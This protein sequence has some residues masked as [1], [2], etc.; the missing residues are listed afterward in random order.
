MPAQAPSA[1]ERRGQPSVPSSAQ[2]TAQGPGP[3]PRTGPGTASA[4]VRYVRPCVTELRLSAFE[5]HRRA[6]FALGAVTLFVGASGSGKTSALRA[7][8]A[9]ARLGGGAPLGEVFADPL[10]C[11]PQGARPDAQRRRGFRIGCT[12][13]GPG[14]PV[15][16]DVAVQAEPELR[17]VGERLSAAGV[18]LLETA[19]RDPGRRTVQAAWHTGGS[20][21][22]TRAPL[23]DDRLGT[24]LLPLR[25][26]GKTD[27]QRQVLAAAEQMVVALRSVFACDP[28]P[29][30]MGV[31]VPTGSGRLLTGCDNLA[32]VLWRTRE[33]CA[34]RHAQLVAALSAGSGAPVVDLRAEPLADGTVRALL[35]RADGSRTELARLGYG[36]LRYVALALVLLTGPGV[37]DVDPAGEV[38]A[39]MQTLTLLADGLDR[40]LD[41]RQRAE[42]L[43]LAVR[44]AERGHIRCVGAVGDGYG[45]ARTEGVTVVHLGA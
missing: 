38:P 26:A 14:G 28:Q 36:E 8:E 43:R 33:E 34:R 16:L 25:V 1:A 31:P 15:R 22:V 41:A 30:W 6:R 24:A 27:G 44:M 10:A 17:I 11:V 13:D 9:L 35:H 4:Q 45:A 23:P 7:Y 19:L 12:A 20:A 3:G 32:D 2:S 18:V 21:P 29:D 37:L 39:A 42:L 5:G 40:G